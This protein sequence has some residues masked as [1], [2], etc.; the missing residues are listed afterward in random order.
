[1]INLVTSGNQ[2]W[3]GKSTLFRPTFK[4]ESDFT[5][6]AVYVPR[7]LAD[8]GMKIKCNRASGASEKIFEKIMRKTMQICV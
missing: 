6:P 5:I 2:K 7:P 3:D 1:M 8:W 4:S